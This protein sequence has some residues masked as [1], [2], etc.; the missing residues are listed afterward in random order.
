MFGDRIKYLGLEV[1]RI[2]VLN[3]AENFPEGWNGAEDRRQQL[4]L[5]D[6]T[7]AKYERL[8]TLSLLEMLLWQIELDKTLPNKGNAQS[9]RKRQKLTTTSRLQDSV[10]TC[11]Q[12]CRVNCGAGIVI[13]NV[14]AFLD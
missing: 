1:W 13:P 14:M 8:E 2:A 4:K 11:R 6:V 9:K 5:I 12:V 10:D 3:E 7:L